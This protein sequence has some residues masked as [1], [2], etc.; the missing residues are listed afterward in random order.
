[1]NEIALFGDAILKVPYQISICFSWESFYCRTGTLADFYN[2]ENN[3]QVL[4][5]FENV[6]NHFCSQRIS[7][8]TTVSCSGRRLL[9][10]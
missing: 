3:V 2:F 9:K 10:F 4:E 7:C 8:D 1:M 6:F 5:E